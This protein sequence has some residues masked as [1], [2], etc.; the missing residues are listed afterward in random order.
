MQ[1]ASQLSVNMLMLAA[2]MLT[3]V[4]TGSEV[5]GARCVNQGN[6]W[7]LAGT[8]LRLCIYVFLKSLNYHF[9]LTLTTPTLSHGFHG[10]DITGISTTRSGDSHHPDTV[11][12][13]SA[14]VGDAV[15]EHIRGRLK[16]TAHLR[17]KK[18]ACLN[19]LSSG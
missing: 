5:S 6:G 9:N 19:T 12:S 1:T 18:T 11:L 15:E 3:Y 4:H 13:V 16:L 8:L 10:D 2:L 17:G 14:Q 7:Y